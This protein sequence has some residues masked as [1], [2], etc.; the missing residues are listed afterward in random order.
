M[1]LKHDIKQTEYQAILKQDIKQTEYQAILKQDIKQT[2]YQAILKQDKKQTEYQ[3]ILMKQV[4]K[5]QYRLY[6]TYFS[7]FVQL[8]RYA[9]REDIR[10][11][12]RGNGLTLHIE[13][14]SVLDLPPND[15]DCWTK[16]RLKAP[17][18]GQ[19]R[20]SRKITSI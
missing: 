11:G 8:R 9:Q 4:T 17:T 7:S 13:W 14:T 10:T 19:N 18:S 20:Y 3:A 1:I 12:N 5:Y 15:D 2:E 16:L 6:K